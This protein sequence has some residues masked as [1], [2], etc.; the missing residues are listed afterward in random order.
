M[1]NQDIEIPKIG[2][3]TW[4]IGG[5]MESDFAHDADSVAVMKKAIQLG[6]THIDT[7]ELYGA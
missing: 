2:L 4:G 5:C 7:A 1:K 3:G 6:Y